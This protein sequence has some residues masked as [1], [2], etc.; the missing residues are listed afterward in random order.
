MVLI[1]T[2]LEKKLKLKIIKKGYIF[3]KNSKV[4]IINILK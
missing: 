3:V 2:F 4:K 1:A